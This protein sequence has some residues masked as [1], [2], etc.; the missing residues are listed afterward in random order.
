VAV[1]TFNAAW[2]E[3]VIALTLINTPSHRT[4]PIGLALFIG[5]HDTAWGALFA[6]SVIATIPS[7]LVYLLAQRWFQAGLSLGGLR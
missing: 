4:L 2:D 1:F 3:F 5:A 7:I 6:G